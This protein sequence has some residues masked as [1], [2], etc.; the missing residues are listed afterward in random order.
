MSSVLAIVHT[1]PHDAAVLAADN[2]PWWP[3]VD[4][5]LSPKCQMSKRKK[6]LPLSSLHAMLLCCPAGDAPDRPRPLRRLTQEIRRVETTAGRG[7]DR[8][9]VMSNLSVLRSPAPSLRLRSALPPYDDDLCPLA[10]L[11]P[12]E[13]KLLRIGVPWMNLP[14][15]RSE[16]RALDKLWERLETTE[17]TN[18]NETWASTT[19]MTGRRCVG[20]DMD[21]AK[22]T[23]Q[24]E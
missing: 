17:E 12:R 10:C 20:G 6:C 13:C 7:R 4:F 8:S 11:H 2:P 22:M 5:V 15:E 14:D 23:T 21:R 24:D 18:E 19:I 1:F 9:V 16:R 3:L